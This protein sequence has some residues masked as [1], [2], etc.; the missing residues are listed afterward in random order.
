[1]LQKKTTIFPS[2]NCIL[3]KKCSWNSATTFTTYLRRILYQI[4]PSVHQ[5]N[6]P[7]LNRIHLKKCLLETSCGHRIHILKAQIHRAL[8]AFQHAHD[9]KFYRISYNGSDMIFIHN[10]DQSTSQKKAPVSEYPCHI[11][12][13]CG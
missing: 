5:K 6:F 1:M 12:L 3:V 13:G 4:P 2:Y 11:H 10:R 7:Y 9:R 8:Y